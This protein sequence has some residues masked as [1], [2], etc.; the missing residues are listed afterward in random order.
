MSNPFFSALI[1]SA[2]PELPEPELLE[3]EVDL[4]GPDLLNRQSGATGCDLGARIQPD[5][6]GLQ[7]E[8]SGVKGSLYWLSAMFNEMSKGQ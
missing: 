4:L 6:S 8:V 7:Q 5:G 3:Q 1:C 2:R